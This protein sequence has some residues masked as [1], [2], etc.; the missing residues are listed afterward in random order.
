VKRLTHRRPS[1]ATV[2]SCIALF[3]SLG[4][5]SYGVATGFIDTR[6]IKDET[7]RSKDV[8]NNSLR[9][10]DLRNN[11]IRGRDIRNS[12]V[13]SRDV[14]LNS[15][16][17]SDILESSLGLV[18]TATQADLLDGIDSTGFL[19]PDATGFAAIPLG[20]SGTPAAG[21][22]APQFDVDPLGY[23][24]LEGVARSDGATGPLAVL[25]TGSRPATTKRFAVY[26]DPAGLVAPEP[27]LI[28]IAPNGEIS[29]VGTVA[30]GDELSLDGITFRVGG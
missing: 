25:P 21:E 7:I 2:I 26:G 4:G 15:L 20:A 27:A 10:Q 16:T 24:H 22:P 18:P 28:T 23:V 11:E 5:V 17:G 8:R 13:I 30:G 1:P 12:S 9:T 3:V 6:E 19:R 29:A 14:G